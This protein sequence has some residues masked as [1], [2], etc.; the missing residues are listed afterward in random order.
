MSSGQYLAQTYHLTKLT[1]LSVNCQSE[2]E[3]NVSMLPNLEE[4]ELLPLHSDVKSVILTPSLRRL[5]IGYYSVYYPNTSFCEV[6]LSNLPN[7]ETL[8]ISHETNKFIGLQ[9]LTTLTTLEIYAGGGCV[10]SEVNMDI[11]TNFTNLREFRCLIKTSTLPYLARA[12]NLRSID[13]QTVNLEDFE[14]LALFRHLT[15]FILQEGIVQINAASSIFS[16]L[17]SLK[18]LK[19]LPFQNTKI[20]EQLKPYL[21]KLWSYWN[22]VTK[23][24]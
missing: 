3:I 16:K 2:A 6:D 10:V 21:P 15:S 7:L 9:S 17:T 23:N 14:C 11:L 8:R 20:M 22:V 18:L 19:G 4:L 12:T 13:I 24:Q 5:H 1:K